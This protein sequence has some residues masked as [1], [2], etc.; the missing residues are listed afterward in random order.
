MKKYLL[1]LIDADLIDMKRRR[2]HIREVIQSGHSGEY[3]QKKERNLIKSI[4]KAEKYR[5][6]LESS[7][8]NQQETGPQER[9]A[10]KLVNSIAD[11]INE[12]RRKIEAG[13]KDKAGPDQRPAPICPKCEPD[14]RPVYFCAE[15]GRR[16]ASPPQVVEV[17][18]TEPPPMLFKSF[19]SPDMCETCGR[20]KR[21]EIVHH[22]NR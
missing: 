21:P 4:S 16:E 3:W 22:C 2:D 17:A 12:V 7:T 9:R 19:G 5:E 11:H 20:M 1:Q 10:E 13:A 6:Q 8:I 18:T 14:T 15:H